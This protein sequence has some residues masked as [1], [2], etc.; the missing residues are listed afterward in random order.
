MLARWTVGYGPEFA[1]SKKPWRNAQPRF[2]MHLASIRLVL[3]RDP[4]K[5]STPFLSE[6]DRV[7]ESDDFRDG[8]TMTAFI[9]VDPKRMNTEIKWVEMR[10]ME[11]EEQDENRDEDD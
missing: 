8:Y 1:E 6:E 7:I 10:V 11:D 2:D 3:E 4:Y 9:K 5:Y